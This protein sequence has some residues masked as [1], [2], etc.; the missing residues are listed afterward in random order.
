MKKYEILGRLNAII[1][2]MEIT[3]KHS[4]KNTTL[5][6]EIKALKSLRNDIRKAR[7]V[8]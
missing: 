2:V 7:K 3:A 6:I 1:D 8:I 4:G 5:G